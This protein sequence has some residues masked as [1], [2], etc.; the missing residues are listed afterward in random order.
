[1]STAQSPQELLYPG[2]RLTVDAF[3]RR[4][5]ALPELKFAELIAA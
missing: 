1:M 3:M 4:W 2:Q 5:G